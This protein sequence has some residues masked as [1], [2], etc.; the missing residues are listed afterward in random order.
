MS[1]ILNKRIKL[2]EK[3]NIDKNLNI[4]QKKALRKIIQINFKIEFLTNMSKRSKK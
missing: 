2:T 3:Y 4:Q 1:V